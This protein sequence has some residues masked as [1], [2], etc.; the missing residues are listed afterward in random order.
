[1]NSPLSPIHHSMEHSFALSPSSNNNISLYEDND[2]NASSPR[3]V[4]NLKDRLLSA[5]KTIKECT[6]TALRAASSDMTLPGINLDQFPTSSNSSEETQDD[7]YSMWLR[8]PI[9][10]KELLE[11][12]ISIFEDND[13]NGG[14]EYMIHERLQQV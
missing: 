2:N 7:K 10:S 1:M 11:R 6:E 3:G 13:F 8:P 9:T 14:M 12:G 5:Q 4:D